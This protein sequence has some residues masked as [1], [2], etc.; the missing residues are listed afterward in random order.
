MTT[1]SQTAIRPVESTAGF[2]ALQ[3]RFMSL[4]CRLQ[5]LSHGLGNCVNFPIELQPAAFCFDETTKEV[6]QLYSDFDS[7]FAGLYERWYDPRGDTEE[8]VQS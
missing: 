3:K 7:A 4:S 6:A 5:A 8:E 1:K 2:R